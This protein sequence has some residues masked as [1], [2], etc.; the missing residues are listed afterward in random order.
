[1]ASRSA[2]QLMDNSAYVSAVLGEAGR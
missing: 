2:Q 1:V